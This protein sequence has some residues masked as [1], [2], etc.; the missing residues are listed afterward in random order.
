MSEE[1]KLK[2]LKDTSENKAAHLDN[3]SGKIL[4][5][6]TTVLAKSI[7]QIFNLSI[8]YS[9]FLSYCRISKLKPL[10]NKG[11]NTAPKN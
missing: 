3:L 1:I 5:Y 9:I 7:F 6:A 8:K 10:F 2:S 4:K 11:S